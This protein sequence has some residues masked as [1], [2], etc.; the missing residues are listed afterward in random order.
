[1]RVF[2]EP[3]I[4]LSVPKQGLRGWLLGPDHG[5]ILWRSQSRVSDL[6]AC[7]RSRMTC[8]LWAGWGDGEGWCWEEALC[9]SWLG[10][11]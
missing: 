5:V 8:V 3:H 9:N 11:R 1:M 10:L 4:C 6:T 7:S 2:S